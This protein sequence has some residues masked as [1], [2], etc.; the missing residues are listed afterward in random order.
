MSA[1]LLTLTQWLSPA[2][3][4][5]GYAY[6]HGLET[7]ISDGVVRDEASLQDWLTVVLT[8]GTG[9]ADAVFLCRARAGEDAAP[10]A[11]A[12]APSRERLSEAETQGAAFVAAVNAMDGGDLPA[13]PLP[14]A[15]G[16]AARRLSL[17]D[18]DVAALYLHAFASNLVS[19]AVRFVP[20]GQNAGQ[21]VLAALHPVITDVAARASD[22][23]IDQISGAAFGSDMASLRHETQEVRL[24]KT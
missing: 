16:V 22:M 2:F 18:A 5:G 6:S 3:P 8:R 23:I 13:M 12:M 7:A 1:D 20:L 9:L 10:M 21:R 15:V 11:R 19:A 4:V 14:V 17:A 24:F